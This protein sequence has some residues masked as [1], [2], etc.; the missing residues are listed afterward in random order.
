[1]KNHLKKWALRVIGV[2]ALSVG[3]LL[4]FVFNPG[5]L[6]A[7]STV[8]KNYRI[9]HNQPFDDALKTHLD[10]ASQLLKKSEL[11]TSDM[12]LDICLN[13]GSVYPELIQLL[14]G[15]AFA[16][17]FSNKVVLRGNADFKNNFVELNGYHWNLLQLLTH[18]MTHCLQFEALGLWDSNP[19]ANNPDW[20]WE[21]Y[22]EYIARQNSDQK[23]LL[24]N[25]H[26]LRET[27]KLDNNGWIDWEDE[28]GT[29]IQYYKSWLLMQYCIDVKGKSYKE[30]LSDI[31]QE[32]ALEKEMLMWY[33]SAAKVK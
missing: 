32:E 6:Y 28:S 24:K 15:T 26:R 11:Y 3:A 10:V 2:S 16:Y 12:H 31:T 9:L 17:G 23:D 7:N 4:I 14:Q 5:L 8:Y 21:G 25:I 1:M 13:D 20:K 22:P 18:E 27:E 33:A 29:V 30:V 19:I